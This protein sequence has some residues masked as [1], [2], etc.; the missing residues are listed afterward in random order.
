MEEKK[1]AALYFE[2]LVYTLLRAERKNRLNYAQRFTLKTIIYW[3]S[4]PPQK[5][6]NLK[7]S[8]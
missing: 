3:F 1:N 7:S 6:R 8:P 2:Y 5:L 4:I